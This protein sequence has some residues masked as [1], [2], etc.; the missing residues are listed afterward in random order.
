MPLVKPILVCIAFGV[1]AI[2]QSPPTLS[3]DAGANRHPISPDI[4]G[5]NDYGDTGLASVARV[6]VRRWGG[7][8]TSR[9]N[10][11]LD[12]DNSGNDYYFE[13]YGF[14]T[15]SGFTLPDG[16]QFDQYVEKGLTTGT[17]RLGTIPVQGWL[18]KSRDS[19]C[20]YSVAKYGPQQ[21]VAPNVPDCGNG[22]KT[23]GTTKIVNDP[24]DVSY[25]VDQT[26]SQQWIQYVIS[27]YGTAERGGVQ[28][29]SL[30]NEP[31][32]W[33]GV[34]MDI[35]PNPSTY[36]EMLSRGQTYA[37]AIKSAD[38]TALVT[39]PVA[40]GWM[41]YF[42]SATDF[43]SGWSTAPYLFYD[44]PVDRLA[45]GNIPFV[46][47]YL[48]QMRQYEQQNGLRLL[49]YVDVHGYIAPN[50]IGF[51]TTSTPD[52]DQLRLTSTRVF[53]DP[54]YAAPDGSTP[55][56]GYPSGEPPYLVPRMLQWVQN[57]YPGTKTAITEYNW[58]ML[59]DI[60]GAIAQADILGIFG[61]EGLDLA[62]VWAPPNPISVNGAPPDPGV[63]AFKLYLN[64]DGYGSQFGE[65]SVSAV[66]SDPDQIS[67]FAATRSDNTLTI[68]VL[69]KTT[70][71]ATLPVTIANYT[72]APTA[73]VWQ[74]SGAD[75]SGIQRVSDVAVSNGG[76][77]A[78][79]PARSMTLLVVP[80]DPSVLPVPKPVVGG[81][82]N[83]ASYDAHAIS[84]GEF[85]YIGGTG[86]GPEGLTGAQ[87]TPDG[88]YL[89]TSLG[90]VRVLIDGIPAPM[91][92]QTGEAIAAIVPYEAGLSSTAAVQVEVEGVRSDPFLI[93]VTSA[94][95]AIF[96]LNASGAGQGAILNQDLSVNGPGNP[97]HPGDV[98]VLYATG[99]GA[100]SPPGVDGRLALDIRPVPG[101]T[102]SVTIGGQ[103]SVVSYC[104][105]APYYASG[106]IQINVQVPAATAGGNAPV[107]LSI[108]GVSSPAAVTV[109]VE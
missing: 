85:I 75:L 7:D 63:N 30:D 62:T 16:S 39:G 53:W 106:L 23:D 15:P 19:G 8:A 73:Q 18:P 26:F 86:F 80:T 94:V 9:Y 24:N 81:V 79:F 36:D 100:T 61:R 37:A 38:P 107:V 101:G 12:A 95:P 82:A 48:Q 93:P 31:E 102:C 33:F 67:I 51:A 92:Y 13:S 91:V 60:T 25:T 84:P 68:A 78:L 70:A 41:G 103:A 58:G 22:Y 83:A 76:L 47:W 35:H 11:M 109:A 49:D 96:S 56:A 21:K 4:Y 14:T 46:E 27:K 28:V 34:H 52:Q 59:N 64:Y 5:I 45:H 50:G 88:G 65:T 55:D 40:A 20:S 43:V 10:W 6:G 42:Y 2:A 1:A 69:N 72:P 77:T 105:A 97:A 90:S 99:E 71:D 44:N 29:W 57:D 3:V 74:Y 89:T 98:V 104:G 32:W 87:A 17:K 54:N 66:T 108:G